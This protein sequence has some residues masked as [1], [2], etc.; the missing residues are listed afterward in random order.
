M[1]ILRM[2]EC[3]FYTGDRHR[4]AF[5]FCWCRGKRKK[6]WLARVCSFVSWRD[7]IKSEVQIELGGSLKLLEGKLPFSMRI[8]AASSGCR[9]LL[10]GSHLHLPNSLPARTEETIFFTF[11]L[12]FFSSL[13]LPSYFLHLLLLFLLLLLVL[14]VFTFF[15]HTFFVLNAYFTLILKNLDKSRRAKIF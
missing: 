14:L 1:E 10:S 9:W 6:R 4:L 7:P 13:H 11:F 3:F 12:L 5:E 2:Y 8:E 15:L